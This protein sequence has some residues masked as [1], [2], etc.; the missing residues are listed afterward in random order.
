MTPHSGASATWWA[1]CC[2]V[3]H[4]SNP[5]NADEPVEWPAG[6]LMPWL[7]YRTRLSAG[8]SGDGRYCA[9]LSLR[10]MR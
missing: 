5:I 7:V 1:S 10:G 8:H 6:V 4:F 9:W 2:T 3:S